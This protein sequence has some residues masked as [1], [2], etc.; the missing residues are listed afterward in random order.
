[1][2]EQGNA[3]HISVYLIIQIMIFFKSFNVKRLKTLGMQLKEKCVTCSWLIASLFEVIKKIMIHL[4]GELFI[5][6]VLLVERNSSLLFQI[7]Q[8]FNDNFLR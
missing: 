2:S 4:V 3:L 7:I 5:R 1:M 8:S 6:H